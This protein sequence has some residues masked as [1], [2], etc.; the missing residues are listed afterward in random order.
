MA[1][2]AT[3]ADRRR[4]RIE[5]VARRRLRREFARYARAA[6]E[7]PRAL[8]RPTE[9]HRDR[10]KSILAAAYEVSI[11]LGVELSE[12][13]LVKGGRVRI[14][15]EVDRDLKRRVV[16]KRAPRGWLV[17]FDG[18]TI[19]KNPTPN[20]SQHGAN[21]EMRKY[22]DAIRGML[23]RIKLEK[24]E[25]TTEALIDRLLAEWLEDRAFMQATSIANSSRSIAQR[26]LE[27][28]LDEGAGESELAR[29]IRRA[30]GG[31]SRARS[32]TIARTETHGAMNNASGAAADD[33]GATTKEWVAIEDTRTRETHMQADGQ[34]VPIS[35]KFNV[36]GAALRFPGDPSAG[37]PQETINCRCAMAYG[38]A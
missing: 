9:Q 37:A 30:F 5:R 16:V 3:I 18:F 28:S 20:K 17:Y 4:M 11:L 34:T 19:G 24:Q 22:K 36:G 29:N 25:D 32:L 23:E 35:G 10:I 12:D 21:A 8:L 27:Q 31:L 15:L 26:I 33:L 1:N 7:S 6:S 13:Q 2:L 38:L 14:A